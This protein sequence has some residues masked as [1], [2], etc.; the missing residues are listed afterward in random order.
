MS[1][2][3]Q[4]RSEYNAEFSDEQLAFLLTLKV[5]SV[6]PDDDNPGNIMIGIR[7]CG[8][9]PDMIEWRS[10]DPELAMIQIKAFLSE[11]KN[12]EGI[13][14]RDDLPQEFLDLLEPP[15]ED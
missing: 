3:D 13:I 11:M 9:S 12:G 4:Y 1:D 5:L 6:Q 8:T 14:H 2:I 10:L 7:R 15:E